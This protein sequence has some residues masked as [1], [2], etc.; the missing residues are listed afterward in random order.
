M[1]RIVYWMGLLLMPI[2]AMSDQLSIERIFADPALAGPTPRAVKVSPDGTRVGLLRGRA[3]DQHQ[4]DLWTYEV[5]DGSLQLRVDS[6]K[7]AP[8]EQVSEAERARR[9][10]ERVADFHG[11]V[12]YD[13]APDGHRV[14]F[15]LSGNLY[16][17]DLNLSAP[18]ALRQLTHGT[19]AVLDPKVSPKG[20]YVSYV[21]GQE[22]WVIDLASG[23]PR[24]LTHDGGGVIHNGE[25]EFVA[26]EEM[27][28]STGYW[29]A[30][31]DSAIAFERYDKTKVPV[32]ST[33]RDVCR[34]APP[35]W[36]SVI[37][38]QAIQTCRSSWV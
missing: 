28:R 21:H 18:T 11:I 30:P 12:D 3:T 36:N 5:K 27:R 6:Q 16:L 2:C 23:K 14:L 17:Y 34:T 32:A 31:D 15:T 10:R 7:L 33:F 22:L 20:N 29:W 13:W 24:Q 38:P 8:A 35:S 4:L 25:A 9:E 19:R 26:Q 1:R 37:R